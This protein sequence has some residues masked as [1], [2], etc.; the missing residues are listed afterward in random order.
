VSANEPAARPAAALEPAEVAGWLRANPRF[1][2]ER[3][4]LYR[5]LVPPERVH[6]EQ[7]ADHMAA[8]LRAERAHAAAMAER[9]D[10]VLAAGRAAA[11]LTARVQEAVLALIRSRHPAECV[12]VELPALLGVDAAALCM[13]AVLPGI[14]PLPEGTVAR[15]LGGRA[16]RFRAAPEDALLLHAEAAELARHDALVRIPGEGPPA[17]LALAARDGRAL[18]PGHGAGALAFLG[19]S[20]AAALGR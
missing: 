20:I 11:G 7:L 9:A 14:R 4:E 8:M 13:E 1:L 3:P 6:G 5:C 19:R 12:A 15:V 16:V 17:L 18:E 10:F 2:A